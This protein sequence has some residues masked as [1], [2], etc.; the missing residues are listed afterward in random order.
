MKN[1]LCLL[2]LHQWIR[3]RRDREDSARCRR[4]GEIYDRTFDDFPRKIL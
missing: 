2:G 1:V 3:E 4:C